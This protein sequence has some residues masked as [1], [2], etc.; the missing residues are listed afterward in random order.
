MFVRPTHLRQKSQH[1]VFVGG[2]NDHFDHLSRFLVCVLVDF[3]SRLD[4][5]C[6]SVWVATKKIVVWPACH[7]LDCRVQF[8]VHFSGDACR[9]FWEE[10]RASGFDCGVLHALDYRTLLDL[11]YPAAHVSTFMATHPWIVCFIHR[12]RRRRRPRFGNCR[13]DV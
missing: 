10:D 6:A 4:F 8:V 2:S 1:W 11:C 5:A 9:S 13:E 3:S 7:W 12:G